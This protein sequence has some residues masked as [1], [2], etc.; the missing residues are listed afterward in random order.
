L[1]LIL[2]DINQ[3]Y[4]KNIYEKTIKNQGPYKFERLQGEKSHLVQSI[5]LKSDLRIDSKQDLGHGLKELIQ[6]KINQ[7]NIILIKK[8]KTIF[9]LKKSMN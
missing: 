4:K 6:N 8:K 3:K 7:N 1:I 9:L 5:I 2:I